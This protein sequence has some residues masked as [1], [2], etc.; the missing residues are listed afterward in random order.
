MKKFLLSL[1]ASCLAVAIGFVAIAANIRGPSS[2]ENSTTATINTEAGIA[3]DA[4]VASPLITVSPPGA[5]A[6]GKT[7]A[8]GTQMTRAGT[9]GVSN[10]VLNLNNDA[11]T[12]NAQSP[13]NELT[14]SQEVPGSPA[15]LASMTAT[16]NLNSR[17]STDIRRYN[18]LI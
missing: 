9:A 15:E 17:G 14:R 2:M 4:Q 6:L 18:L 8:V 3:N 13:N 5:V 10:L 7:E 16:I 1:V 11:Q 12:M